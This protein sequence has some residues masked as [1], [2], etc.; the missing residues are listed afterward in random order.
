MFPERQTR[1]FLDTARP[2]ATGGLSALRAAADAGDGLGPA[3]QPA[4]R[5]ERRVRRVSQVRTGRRPAPA[6]LAGLR[7]IGP[8]LRQGVRGRHQPAVLPGAGYQRLDGLRHGGHDQDGVRPEDRRRHRAPGP[9][10]GG[11]GRLDLRRQRDR[12]Q[13]PA[14]AE[15]LAL[16]GRLRRAGAGE[17]AG[18]D[19]ARLGAARAGR[20]RSA[21]AR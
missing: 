19:P 14:A 13:H 15:P 18:R 21:S 8:V 2:V 5:L 12:A 17:A 6:G 11:R 20:D 7:P 1:S 9:P 4:P 10:A 3:P 16:D